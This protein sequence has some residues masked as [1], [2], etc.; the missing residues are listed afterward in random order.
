MR[1]VALVAALLIGPSAFAGGL[2][3][4]VRGVRPLSVGGAFVASADG[5]NALWANPARLDESGALVEL[6]AVLLQAS[7]ASPDGGVANARETTLPNP[8]ISLTGK[9][10]D[11]LTIGGGMYA[12]YSPQ[13][14]FD[15]TGPQRYALV[16]SDQSTISV[17]AIGAA[18]RFGGFELGFTVQNVLA[19]IRQRTVMSGYTGV[20][21]SPSDPELDILNELELR[22]DF[23]L[24]GNFGLTF[25][26]GPVRLGV[27]LQ[28][29][30]T[31]GGRA[32]FRV[33]LPT[34]VFF[35]AASVEG[36]GVDFE[37]PFPMQL[38]AG[39]SLAALDNLSLELSM[40]WQDWSVQDELR[41]DPGGR[42]RLTGVP[43]IGNYEVPALVVDRRM[44]DTWSAH[45]GADWGLSENLHLRGGVFGETS[46]FDDATFS[47]AQLDG[48]KLGIA[49]GGRWQAGNF[50]VDIAL[51]HVMQ[52]S[53]NITD[54]ELRQLN[55]TNPE[56]T[57][58]IGNGAYD[59][60]LWI[61]GLG[62][63]YTF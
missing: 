39:V 52:A 48:D 38:R 35:D 51:A 49:L 17:L 19:H 24:S 32:D 41:I 34:S 1:L 56:Q 53:R 60:R 28:L 31:I 4:P 37:I 13:H 6:G 16:A 47:V 26:E 40:T 10:T 59:S 25:Q 54:S 2:E 11:W 55:P 8:T 61:G 30:Y 63:G 20:F 46:A 29:P 43:S 36:D 15:E 21:G 22:D 44:K 45:L 23:T 33:R 50:T 18:V 3:L 62:V 27:A 57:V 5:G 7:Y 58:V 42:I 9:L 12:P 14:G